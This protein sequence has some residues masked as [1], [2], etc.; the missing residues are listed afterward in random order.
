MYDLILLH[1]GAS[2]RAE[3]VRRLQELGI[4]PDELMIIEDIEEEAETD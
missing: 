4:D 2:T 3:A 1:E